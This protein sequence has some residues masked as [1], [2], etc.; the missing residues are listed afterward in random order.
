MPELLTAAL[1]ILAGFIGLVWSAD[2]FVG[3][4]AAIAKLAGM[5]PL[6]IG[7]TIV[8]LG[9]SAPE[10]MVSASAALK[11]KGDLAV[12]N[13]I[14]SNLANIGMVL[15]IT[16]LIA[17][18]PI[19]GHLLKCELPILLLVTLVGGYT[20]MDAELT[21]FDG[22][23][24]SGLLVPVMLYMIYA[25]T[26]QFS[27]NEIEAEQEEIPEMG[28]TSAWLWFAIGL[29][30][31]VGSAEIL[32][33]GAETTALHFGVSPLVVGLTVI[34]VGTSLPELAAS[35]ASALKGHLDIALGN[36]IGSN[37]FNLL[38]VMAVPGLVQTTAI[39]PAAFNRDYLAMAGLTALLAIAMAAFYLGKKDKKQAAIGWPLGVVLLALYAGYYV[40][41]FKA[42]AG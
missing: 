9:T 30:V 16:A 1:F 12:G 20:I 26:R 22:I 3:A 38:A 28:K 10:I 14:G 24:L 27:P 18:L 37:I 11:G 15:G 32:V 17:R 19:Q 42:T 33:R 4:S 39:E 8:S 23:L 6:L 29:V 41:L 40:L 36:V 35:I 34:A 25:K 13:A 5:P 31:L 2:R 7:L 21:L